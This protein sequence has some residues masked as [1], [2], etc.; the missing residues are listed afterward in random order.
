MF[1][2][3]FVYII[4]K[5]LCRECA[6]FQMPQCVLWHQSF[7]ETYNY[8]SIWRYY[9]NLKCFWTYILV[10][11]LFHCKDKRVDSTS[12]LEADTLFNFVVDLL[13]AFYS[14]NLILSV[15]DSSFSRFTPRSLKRIHYGYITEVH[16]VQGIYI[17][18]L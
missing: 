13:S 5:L 1:L 8:W 17:F 10:V 7:G 4:Y 14:F 12:V 9:L 18:A 2:C 16:N 11:Y 15:F 6:G 3:S